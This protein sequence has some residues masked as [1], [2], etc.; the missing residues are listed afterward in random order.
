MGNFEQVLFKQLAYWVSRLEIDSLVPS[1]SLDLIC[2]SDTQELECTVVFYGIENL[3]SHYHGDPSETKD[4][5]LCTLLGITDTVE[6]GKTK[7]IITTDTTEVAF[8]TAIEPEIAWADP[9]KPY[10]DFTE[11][12]I[13][14]GGPENA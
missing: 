11:E 8:C 5:Y 7:Y 3:T 13:I 4:T 10:Q 14:M 2:D 9:G 6:N 12:K 1:V